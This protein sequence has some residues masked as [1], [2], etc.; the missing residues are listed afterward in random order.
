MRCGPV[1]RRGG[2]GGAAAGGV[3]AEAARQSQVP[4]WPRAAERH[5]RNDW[6]R[7]P[8]RA[9]CGARRA[10][11]ARGGR[12]RPGVAPGAGRGRWCR[13]CRRAGTPALRRWGASAGLPRVR[14]PRP[15]RAP[16][17]G[18]Q[19][20]AIGGGGGGALVTVDGGGS[21][22]VSVARVQALHLRGSLLRYG[23]RAHAEH[24]GQGRVTGRAQSAGCVHH[25]PGVR[26]R[27]QVPRLVPHAHVQDLLIS[28]HPGDGPVDLG[29]ARCTGGTH[30]REVI[31]GQAPGGAGIGGEDD[32]VRAV[33]RCAAR[34]T[35][36][37]R[38]QVQP[39]HLGGDD[40]SIVAQ[41]HHGT[42]GVLLHPHGSLIVQRQQRRRAL[43][44]IAR[45]GWW[46]HVRRA[47]SDPR[48]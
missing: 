39:A 24:V 46:W 27:P 17:G 5:R 16:F 15:P 38:G 29:A 8:R 21:R 19:Q 12:H 30:P 9:R 35:R 45:R 23:V 41:P 3:A 2:G 14:A 47:S 28:L 33:P 34:C 31:V 6:P 25:P 26:V 40:G 43:L 36:C 1:R 18:R 48:R 10:S 11:A 32:L 42:C 37:A 4:V 7:Q 20:R 44:D 22:D 13:C